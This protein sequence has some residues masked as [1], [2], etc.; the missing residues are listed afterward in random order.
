MSLTDVMA[1]SLAVGIPVGL[2]AYAFTQ[3]NGR[4]RPIASEGDR[5][6]ARWDAAQEEL[7]RECG[8]QF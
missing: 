7:R 6:R 4:R 5:Y 3:V 1:I 8:P 2:L